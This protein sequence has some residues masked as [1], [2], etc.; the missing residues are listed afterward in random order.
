[1]RQILTLALL[2]PLCCFAQDVALTKIF[3]VKN[4]K[5][6]YDSTFLLGPIKDT[7][8][9]RTKQW[10]SAQ[11]GYRNDIFMTR[12]ADFNS[13]DYEEF[14]KCRITFPISFTSLN[15]K[16]HKTVT[17]QLTYQ[18]NLRV[19]VKNDLK[20]QVIMDEVCLVGNLAAIG[21]NLDKAEK[22][23]L[24]VEDYKEEQESSK[25]SKTANAT[26]ER[27]AVYNN[28]KKADAYLRKNFQQLITLLQQSAIPSTSA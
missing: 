17:T 5:V 18:Y 10:V 24:Y 26:K 7:V 19:Y 25:Q 3:P 15:N 1:M 12:T 8:F 9:E 21:L 16:Q 23:T 22:D 28:Y 11:K 6:R 4:G 13:N 20:V 27:T 14:V 2:L